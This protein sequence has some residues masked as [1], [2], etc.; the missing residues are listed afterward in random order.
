MRKQ[1][2]TQRQI[3]TERKWSKIYGTQQNNSKRRVHGDPSLSQKIRK[4]SNKQRNFVSR[5]TR[6]STNKSQSLQKER[7]HKDQ[8]LQINKIETKKIIERSMNQRVGSSEI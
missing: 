8:I 2:N 5:R 4:L 7:N 3:K 1:K 6:K